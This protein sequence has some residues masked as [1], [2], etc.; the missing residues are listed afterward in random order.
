MI[1]VAVLYL[2]P[3]LPPIL[4]VMILVMACRIVAPAFSISFL[5]RAD[6]MQIFSAG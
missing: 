4:R 2:Y 3:A 5:E 6:V 1:K